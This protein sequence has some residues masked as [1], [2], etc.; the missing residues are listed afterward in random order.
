M[1]NLPIRLMEKKKT[2]WKEDIV[3]D[4]MKDKISK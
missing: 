2:T 4:I 1:Y 3:K